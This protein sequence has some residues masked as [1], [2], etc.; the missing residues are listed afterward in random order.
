MLLSCLKFSDLFFLQSSLSVTLLVKKAP[1][2]IYSLQEHARMLLLFFFFNVRARTM[3]TGYIGETNAICA[4]SSRG[5][6]VME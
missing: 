6:D 4:H 2:I 3:V 5:Q 1:F